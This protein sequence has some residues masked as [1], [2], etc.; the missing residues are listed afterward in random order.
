MRKY[1]QKI[2]KFIEDHRDEMVEDIIRIC[3]INSQKSPYVEGAPFGEGPKKA[4]AAALD[5]AQGY[6]FETTNYDNYA[7]LRDRKS[8]V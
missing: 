6:G 4:L 2:E 8:V 7:G 1:R 5:M 3:S